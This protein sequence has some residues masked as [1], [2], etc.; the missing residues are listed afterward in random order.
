MTEYE[1]LTT[2]VFPAMITPFDSDGRIDHETLADEARY[3][4]SA[5]VD[6]LVPVGSTGES[7]TLS[8]DEHIE[9]VETVVEAVS[10][11][12]VIAGAGSNNTQ[13]A[14]GLGEGA[15]AAGADGLLL[16]S[17]YYNMP[18]PSG[19]QAH[20]EA[21][22]DAVALPQIVYNVPGR[23]G[24][25]IEPETTAALAEHER[26]VGYKA[27]SGDLAMINTVIE[28]TEGLDFHVLAGD[29]VLTLPICAVGGNGVVSVAAN[30]DPVGVVELTH[31]ALS[32]DYEAARVQQRRLGPLFRAIFA[33]TNP[34]PVKEGVAMLGRCDPYLRSPLSRLSEEHRSELRTILEELELDEVARA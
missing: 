13:E 4:E 24:R 12:P 23:T 8:H 29:D 30:L 32:G 21:I 2:G 11:I 27:A 5:G 31:A 18:E 6:G 34:I 20:F 10:D 14:I 33:E 7:A 25:T 16:I 19:M 3:L 15:A 22:A 28:L 9:V 1:S 26:I 17:P